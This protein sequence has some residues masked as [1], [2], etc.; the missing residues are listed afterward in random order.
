MTG[1]FLIVGAVFIVMALS[2]TL[3]K[4]LPLSTSMLYLGLGYALGPGGAGLLRI[5]LH[6]DALLIGHLAE[7]AVIVSLFTAGLKLRVRLSDDNWLLPV[8]LASVSMVVTV[9]SI[10]AIGV[11]ALGLPLGAAVLLGAILSPTDPVLA[12]E[13]QVAHPED[14]DRLRFSLTG[15]AGLNDGT[16]FPFVM[17][18]LGLLG[19]H[20]LGEGWWRWLVIDVAWAVAA[21]IGI[22]WIL[23]ALVGR[24]VLYLRREH[25]E[26]VGLDDF[27]CLGL[28]ALAYGCGIAASA[29]GFLAVFAAGLS[30]RHVE[31]RA[32]ARDKANGH[33]AARRAP[34][35]ASPT[36]SPKDAAVDRQQAPSFLVAAVLGFNEQVE[37]IGEVVLVVVVGALLATVTIPPAAWWFVALLLVVVRPASVAIGVVGSR[38]STPQRL[39]I[40]WFGIRGI[41]SLYYLM[42]ALHRGVDGPLAELLVGLTLAAITVSVVVHGLSVT[43]LMAVYERARAR[44]HGRA[45]SR[46]SSRGQ[47]PPTSDA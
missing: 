5:D 36:L 30:L 10:A 6:E 28:I 11:V 8:R 35:D 39:M 27:L 40:G 14:R 24:L 16:A 23:G 29:Y 9:A 26:A 21:G 32:S 47:E 18:G 43:P 19:L 45:G 42:F 22:G 37:R 17:L 4:R 38:A 41:G 20:A 15:E 44:R 31:M 13:V 25:R 1:W 46:D 7:V 33:A 3:L 12:S 2:S 34:P